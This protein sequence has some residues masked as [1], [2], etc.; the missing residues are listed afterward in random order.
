MPNINNISDAYRSIYIR[1]KLQ[2]Y[3]FTDARFDT[4]HCHRESVSTCQKA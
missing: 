2:H 3:I 4:V 1:T